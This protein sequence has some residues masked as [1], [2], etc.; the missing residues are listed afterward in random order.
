MDD[1]IVELDEDFNVC[2]MYSGDQQGVSLGSTSVATITIINDDGGSGTGQC[3]VLG[4]AWGR[5]SRAWLK[6]CCL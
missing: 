1:D 5:D 6:G 2:L 3:V 4:V